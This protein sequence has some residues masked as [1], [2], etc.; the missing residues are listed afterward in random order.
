MISGIYTEVLMTGLVL[1]HFR[2]LTDR[3]TEGWRS[4]YKLRCSNHTE[5]HVNLQIL[6]T[7]F[8]GGTS[9]F[10]SANYQYL[11]VNDCHSA[12]SLETRT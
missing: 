7:V 12:Q 11:T 8:T 6:G 10:P 1:V 2:P 4:V 5:F 9:S 3:Q